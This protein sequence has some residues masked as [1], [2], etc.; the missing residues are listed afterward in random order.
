MAVTLYEKVESR[1]LSE[2]RNGALF[3]A[4]FLATGSSD[5]QAIRRAAVLDTPVSY[6]GSL[7]R[8]GIDVSPRGGN[9]YWD[10]EIRYT[11]IPAGEAIQ[12][13][14]LNGGAGPEQPQA[15]DP[16]APL[17]PGF[18]FSTV[19]G[20]TRIYQNKSTVA[21]AQS[22]G[23]I[24]DGRAIKDH[25]GAIGVTN[26]G[27][28]GTDIVSK[29]TEFQA[30]VRRALVTVNYIR[31][32]SALTGSVND[33]PFYGFKRGE[34]LY[35]GAEGRFSVNDLWQ[36]THKFAFEP[37]RQNLVV[38]RDE[39]GVAQITIP[40]ETL[41]WD[42]VDVEYYEKFVGGAKVLRPEQATVHRVYD[43]VNF[44]LL[45]IGT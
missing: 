15:P 45:E 12:N 36:I 43:L 40:G 18:G 10:V 9:E 3:T 24:A 42:F 17:G 6:F 41:G 4:I 29:N 8:S 27:A 23:A 2:D 31:T 26:E 39:A 37:N 11:P 44:A 28:Q 33:S 7:W 1:K 32:L 30:D 22:L 20:T 19:G 34:F 16:A 35:L 38:S 21:R 25:H 13:P 14:G 5:E